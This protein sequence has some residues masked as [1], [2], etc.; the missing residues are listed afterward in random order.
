[1]NCVRED[2]IRGTTPYLVYEID[3]EEALVTDITNAKITLRHIGNVTVK[4]YED[5]IINE[6][7][8]TIAYH[9]TQGDTLALHAGKELVAT[10]HVMVGEERL[11]D[12]PPFILRVLNTDYN[13]VMEVNHE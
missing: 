2:I 5:L 11:Q 4:G 8:N 1:M 12:M 13:T 7:A 9:F 3:R 10:L 6:E